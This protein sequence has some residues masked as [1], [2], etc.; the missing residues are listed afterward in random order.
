MQ[1]T[2]IARNGIAPGTA[3]LAGAIIRVGT[4]VALTFAGASAL[5]SVAGAETTRP[6]LQQV[7]ASNG[8][9]ASATTDGDVEIGRIVT[10]ENTGNSIVTGDI[11]GPAEI[12]G[13]EIDYP[14]DVTVT[15]ILGP[16][17][18]TADGGDAG[19]ARTS[20]D[21]SL[22]EGDVNKDT[23]KDG[24]DITIINRNENRSRSKAIGKSRD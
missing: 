24:E 18:A 17:T 2:G 8:G 14:T 10:G 16:P 6:E 9:V 15:Q 11:G 23:G 1:P 19:T 22:S 7:G 3:Q 13:G 21:D 4:A 12:D 20:D 5:I